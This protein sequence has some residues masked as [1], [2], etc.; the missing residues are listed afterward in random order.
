[1]KRAF[2]TLYLVVTS[3]VVLRALINGQD[4]INYFDL[5][6]L[7]L[8]CVPSILVFLLTKKDHDCFKYVI[9]TSIFA[10][11]FGL[12]LGVILTFSKGYFDVEATFVGVGVALLPMLYALLLSLLILPFQLISKDK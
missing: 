1:M 11:F 4:L 2:L 10:G 5:T 12:I 3:L 8:V 6:S 9:L 7:S